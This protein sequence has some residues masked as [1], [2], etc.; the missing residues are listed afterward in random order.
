MVVSRQ[1]VGFVLGV[2]LAATAP[3][4][5]AADVTGALTFVGIQPCRIVDTR[6]VGGFTGQ[7]GPPALA[8]GVERTFQITGTVPGV[9]AQCGIPTNAVAIAGNFTVAAPTGAGNLRAWPAGGAVPNASILN[10]TTGVNIANAA[11]VPLG[12]SGGEGAVTVRADVAGTQFI[13]DISGYY[14]ARPVTITLTDAQGST[15]ATTTTTVASIY[16]ANFRSEGHDQ[17][18]LVARFN[19]NQQAPACTGNITVELVQTAACSATT[20]GTVLATLTRNCGFKAWLEYSTPFTIPTGPA[21]LDLRIAAV[22]GTA[23]WRVI[24]LELMR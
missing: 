18:R 4:A 5:S 8:A 21:C 20:G 6:G 19:N 11:P 17:A 14:V 15:T 9:P 3:M 13:L 24:E 1:V 7:A 12:I 16:S 22:S 23:A 2:G 10:Y